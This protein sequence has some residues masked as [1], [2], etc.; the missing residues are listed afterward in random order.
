MEQ[1]DRSQRV[2]WWGSWK[3][4]AEEHICIYARP[5]NTD[6]NVV[7]ACGVGGTGWRKAKAG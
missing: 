2:A 4:L 3:R 6:N 7:K 1:T 5:I